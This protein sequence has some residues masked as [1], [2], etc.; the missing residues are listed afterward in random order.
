MQTKG[1]PSYLLA[2]KNFNYTFTLK[3]FINVND[4]TKVYL[5]STC[6]LWNGGKWIK[7]DN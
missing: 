2:S 6:T 5:L 4:L 1:I 7:A 3:D